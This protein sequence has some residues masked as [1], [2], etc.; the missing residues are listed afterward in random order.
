MSDKTKV[1]EP[2]D[3]PAGPPEIIDAVAD[4]MLPGIEE[5][6]PLRETIRRGGWAIISLAVPLVMMEQLVRDATTTLAPDIQRTFG[7]EDWMLIAVLGFSGVALT[8]GG[9]IAAFQIGRAHV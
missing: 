9:P 4:A 6:M 7:L 1:P 5:S 3:L 2:P 8:A